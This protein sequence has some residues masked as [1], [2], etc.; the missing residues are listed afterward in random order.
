MRILQDIMGRLRNRLQ[1]LYRR[2]NSKGKSPGNEVEWYI[3][4]FKQCYKCCNILC[5][6]EGFP[7]LYK[8]KI[9]LTVSC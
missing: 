7:C 8:V 9:H 2:P 1:A 6:N 4:I 3:S 5:P